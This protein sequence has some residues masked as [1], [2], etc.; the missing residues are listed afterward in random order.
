MDHAIDQG[1]AFGH[2]NGTNHHYGYNVR[3]IY[4]AMW[5]MRD[6]IGRTRQDRRIRQGAGLLERPGGD[7][8]TLRLRPRR[9]ARLVAHAAHPQDRQRADAA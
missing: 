1:F 5:L 8:Q 6:K 4:D 3:K 2:G 7:P 9:A